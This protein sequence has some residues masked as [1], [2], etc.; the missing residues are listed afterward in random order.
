MMD[1]SLS[2][3]TS[4]QRSALLLAVV[5][6]NLQENQQELSALIQEH[7]TANDEQVTPNEC[8]IF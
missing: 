4:F 8:S 2:L 6:A 3:S 5:E 7:R 1:G